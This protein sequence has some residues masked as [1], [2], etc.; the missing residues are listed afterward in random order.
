MGRR[1]WLGEAR[2]KKGTFPANVDDF[3]KRFDA[4]EKE[5]AGDDDDE[6]GGGK[7][8]EK[9]EEK[10]PDKKGGKDGKGDEA[11]TEEFQ[12]GP[13]AIVRSFCDLISDYSEV[14]EDRDET[15]N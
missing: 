5:G 13:T 9:K 15:L 14:W 12:A 4:L 11:E 2:E 8:A 3:Y 10:K 1:Q 7:K 6:D